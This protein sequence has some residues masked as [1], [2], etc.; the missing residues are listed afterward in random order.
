MKKFFSFALFLSVLASCGGELSHDPNI[1]RR[2]AVDFSDTVAV[3]S[4][5]PASNEQNVDPLTDIIL[6]FSNPVEVSDLGFDTLQIRTRAGK[7][8]VEGEYKWNSNRTRVSFVPE[9]NDFRASLG[10]NTEYEVIL[11]NLSDDGGLLIPDYLFR[12]RTHASL[13][14]NTK[15]LRILDIKPESPV[16]NPNETIRIRFS[17]PIYYESDYGRC[18][19]SRWSDTFKVINIQSIGSIGLAQILGNVCVRRDEDDSTKGYNTLEFYPQQIMSN[20]SI[21]AGWPNQSLMTLIIQDSED[22]RGVSGARLE[23]TE[24]IVKGTLDIETGNFGF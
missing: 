8:V 21:R 12:F 3:I 7:V 4:H 17:E 15:G 19:E 6:D 24:K 2:D 11:H 18:S 13:N 1:I 10:L 23:E 22:L 9:I 14:S 5:N 16:I 20:R